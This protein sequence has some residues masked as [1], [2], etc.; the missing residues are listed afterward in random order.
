M[1]RFVKRALALACLTACAGPET[2]HRR[3]LAD[4]Y[5]SGEYAAAAERVRSARADYGASNEVL[6]RLELGLALIDAAQDENAD[7]ELARAQDRMEE[8]W[9]LSVS[10]RAGAALANENVDDYRGE[11]FERALSHTFR[12]LAFARR[13]MTDSAL[14]EARRVE[15]FLDTQT[16]AIPRQRTYRDDAFARWLA[17]RLYE[18]AGKEDDA[19][20]S[21]A[22][23]ARAYEEWATTYPGRA[24][25]PSSGKGP[26]ELAV[27]VLEGPSP[28]KERVAGGGP[29]GILL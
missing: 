12:A 4:F 17:A 18:D 3:T 5:A 9:T 14:V 22:A 15:A 6:Y 10:Q 23:A 28:R 27:I 19:R 8:L 20:I 21:D 25:G 11:D 7:P 2:S 24:P 13:G 26:S 16:R 29:L 1:T